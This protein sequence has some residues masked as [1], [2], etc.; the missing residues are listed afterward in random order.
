MKNFYESKIFHNF[1]V[2]V[3]LLL[4]WSVASFSGWA[5]N[6][7][8]DRLWF[9][10][11]SEVCEA[12]KDI[13]LTEW[14]NIVSS[15]VLIT[16]ATSLVVILG[17]FV[18]FIVGL[19]NGFY[20]ILKWP[21]DFWRSIPPIVVIAIFINLDNTRDEIYWRVWLVVFGTLPIMVMQIADAINSSS[22]KRMLIFEPLNTSII[23]RVK[24]IIFYEI[25]TALFS[26]TRTVI[27]LAVVIIIVTEMLNAP[28]Y[29]IGKQVHDYQGAY[30]IPYVYAYAIITGTIGLSLNESL[31]FFERKLVSWEH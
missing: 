22:K 20:K 4:I 12:L 17:V 19:F 16:K 25:R 9:A 6:A 26:T 28:R 2:I 7:T 8:A 21:I 24:N 5:K 18:G 14:I 15:F 31:R 27:S 10:G 1:F 11:V 30:Q 3:L 23:F 13:L 29:G